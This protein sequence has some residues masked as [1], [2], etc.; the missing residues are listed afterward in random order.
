M[1][2][3]ENWNTN[4]MMGK[5]KYQ[6][7]DVTIEIPMN[8]WENWKKKKIFHFLLDPYQKGKVTP[9]SDEFA[10]PL[11]VFMKK[12]SVCGKWLWKSHFPFFL[13]SRFFSHIFGSSKFF[14]QIFIKK[15]EFL[16]KNHE[17]YGLLKILWSSKE[18]CK[19]FPR[20]L[21]NWEASRISWR[22]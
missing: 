12:M 22:L 6:R 1:K 11:L 5:L 15:I 8:W 3:R 21:R 13:S 16:L 14:K 19:R 7:N 20:A 2:C 9:E 18:G 4:E 10:F 17:I